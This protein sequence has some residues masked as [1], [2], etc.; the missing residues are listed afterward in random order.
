M[1]AVQSEDF[2]LQTSLKSKI[3][4]VLVPKQHT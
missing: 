2:D 3:G 4:I 1:S